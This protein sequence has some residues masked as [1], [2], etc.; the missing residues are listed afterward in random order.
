MYKTTTRFTS[1]SPLSSLSALLGCALML[2]SLTLFVGCGEEEESDSMMTPASDSSSTWNTTCESNDECSGEINLC[3]LNP[4][5]PD[6]PGYCS[7][8]CTTTADCAGSPDWTCNVVGMCD[9]FLASWCGPASEIEAG[10]GAL[11]MCN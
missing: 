3:V 5:T 8:P 4:M 7:V 9:G 6:A 11:N 10:N 2:C 1:F